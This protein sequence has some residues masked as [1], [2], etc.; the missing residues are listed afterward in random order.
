MDKKLLAV[1]MMGALAMPA[2]GND[3][4]R[5]PS[6]ERGVGSWKLPRRWGGRYRSQRVKRNRIG[7]YKAQRAANRERRRL[8]AARGR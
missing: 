5:L 8:E 3:V 7:A 2:L 4:M 6:P 1:A